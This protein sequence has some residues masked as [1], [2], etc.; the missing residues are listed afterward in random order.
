VR[1]PAVRVRQNAPG[2]ADGG[3]V[4]ALEE[5]PCSRGALDPS[6]LYT[7]AN[8][9]D[10]K[11][12]GIA[13]EV[14]R[15]PMTGRAIASV[16]IDDKERLLALGAVVRSARELL[17][18]HLAQVLRRH[19]AQFLGVQETQALLDGLESSCPALVREVS[20]KVPPSLMTEVLRK[21]VEEGVSI[22]NLRAI[23]EALAE[24]AAEGDA[25][26]LAERAR[27][28]L[29]RHLSHRYAGEGPLQA[30]LVDPIVEETLRQAL[31]SGES[32][33]LA[34]DPDR[35]VN[36]LD[37]LKVALRGNSNGVIL[38]PPDI[39]RALRRLIEASF[40]EVAVLTYS[41]LNSDLQV[42]PVGK[43]AFAKAA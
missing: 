5:I 8:P 16:S 29:K 20:Q 2:L 40:P 21:L 31:R 26:A 1:F 12:L 13:F 33:S 30:L 36:L 25:N 24:P 23:L 37:G 7:G 42:R 43:L 41:E 6:R 19:A 11:L 4:I 10:L 39:R 9:N 3:Y 35:A 27:R 14:A 38:A 28:A 15:D 32:G 22:R 34:I 18:I 17:L